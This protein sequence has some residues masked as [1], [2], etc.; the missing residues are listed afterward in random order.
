M[1]MTVW[2]FW[3]VYRANSKI[4]T[5]VPQ[6]CVH[7]FITSN[8]IWPFEIWKDVPNNAQPSGKYCS[9]SLVQDKALYTVTKILKKNEKD[10]IWYIDK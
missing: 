8:D 2:R 10:I 7:I 3:T 6:N 4:C 9:R 5:T 1:N